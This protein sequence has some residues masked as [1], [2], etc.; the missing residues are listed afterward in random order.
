MFR[1]SGDVPSL[2]L[3]AFMQWAGT[4]FKVK[5]K[6]NRMIDDEEDD[7]DD[8]NLDIWYSD[9]GFSWLSRDTLW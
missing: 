7:C 4:T 1:M 5:I 2:S 9:Y 3:C 8:T 6:T